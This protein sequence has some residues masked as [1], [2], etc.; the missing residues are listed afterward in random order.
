MLT[1]SL[2]QRI[3]KDEDPMGKI[4]KTNNN[5]FAVTGVILDI[6]DNSHFRF[7]ALLPAFTNATTQEEKILTLWSTTLFTYV[8]LKSGAD[9]KDIED[10]FYTF[11]NK[12]MANVGDAIQG[13]F[14]IKLERLDKIHLSSWADFDLSK[15][16]VKYLVIF[17][18]IGL[19]I[20]LLAIINYINMATAR[21]PVRAREAGVRKVLGSGKKEL[22]F[23]FVGESILL[24][25]LALMIAISAAEII[26]HSAYFKAL[27]QKDLSEGFMGSWVIWFASP[28]M[29][30]LVGVFSGLYPA[31]R[32]AKV[33]TIMALKSAVKPNK[34]EAFLRTLMVGF[35]VTVS[36]TLVIVAF[37]MAQQISF[38]NQKDLGFNKND[39]L[40]IPI[41]DSI[42]ADKLD[43]I[44]SVLMSH[45][46]ILSYSSSTTILGAT[47]G[48][49][50][51][52]TDSVETENQVVDFMV[53]GENYF[54]TMEIDFV[55]G[56]GFNAQ[57]DSLENVVV[58]NQ[59]FMNQM[60]WANLEDKQLF[61]NIDENGNSANSGKVVGVT[62]NFN[63][64]SLHEEIRP[65]VFYYQNQPKGSIHLRVNSLNY[66]SVVSFLK[67]QWKSIDPR[68][69]LEF[70]LLK[71]DLQ[72][73]YADDQRLAKFIRLLTLIAIVIS[74]V[75]L[76]SLASFITRIRAKEL[77]VRKVLGATTQQ[78]LAS[79][80]KDVSKILV[81]AC[82]V[83]I[84]LSQLFIFVWQNS[85]TVG[86]P[87]DF[88]VYIFT[89]IFTFLLAFIAVGFHALQA[90]LT[91]PIDI[92]KYE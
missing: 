2:A 81:V 65:L 54:K 19:I 90:A 26:L 8:K 71:N 5:W 29:A 36:V 55:E 75:G 38:I 85:F 79:I 87:L 66:N 52:R 18:S 32:I 92:L 34:K 49:S 27:I 82:L 84:P 83:S 1:Q 16:N 70:S 4:I 46:D 6:P 62:Q 43:E 53:V 30:L 24:S 67:E 88:G 28:L 74:C 50:I 31:F 45:K 72:K 57:R 9:P 48:K 40:L 64:Y 60:N 58:V 14:D 13:D 86:A 89:L 17:V 63:A 51:V 91:N 78:V 56:S 15:G 7:S 76:L 3:F 11:Y 77:A 37:T 23:Q 20:L 22:I 42:I 39:I 73:L 69:P 80:L 41:Q 33:P 47:V 44:G 12:Y 25:F 59:A 35:Q 10:N 68:R 61:W 21:T